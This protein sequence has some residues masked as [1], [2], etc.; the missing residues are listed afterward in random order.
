MAQQERL[1]N[2]AKNSSATNNNSSDV[3]VED[4]DEE[5]STDDP[6]EMTDNTPEARIKVNI[7]SS[8]STLILLAYNH[9]DC[10]CRAYRFCCCYG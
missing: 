3:T 4:V 2:E 6:N 1:E 7:I 8:T 9:H 5:I 10:Y